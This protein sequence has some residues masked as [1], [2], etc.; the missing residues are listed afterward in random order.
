[1]GVTIVWRD[2]VCCCRDE[3]DGGGGWREEEASS[4]WEAVVE[5]DE[6]A[7]GEGLLRFLGRYL[8]VESGEGWWRADGWHG[9]DYGIP[10][11]QVLE[12]R[13]EG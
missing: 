1:M 9:N 5:E 13:R 8:W 6:D 12:D 4:S 11:E 10:A 2:G 7:N 3:G